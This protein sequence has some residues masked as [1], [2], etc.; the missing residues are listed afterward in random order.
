MCRTESKFFCSVTNRVGIFKHRGFFCLKLT[1]SFPIVSPFRS[2]CLGSNKVNQFSS[3]KALKLV[4]HPGILNGSPKPKTHVTCYCLSSLANA[5]SVL[6]F[7]WVPFMDQLLLL[8]SI[9]LTY[10]AGVIP[11]ERSTYS[12][13]T[14]TPLVDVVTGNSSSSGR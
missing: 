13:Q 14:N 3:W 7:G 6:T 2:L 1:P 10:M 12:T 9:T 8:A 5:D 4:P 11:A